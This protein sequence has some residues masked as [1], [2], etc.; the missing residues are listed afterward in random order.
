MLKRIVYHPF[1]IRLFNWEYWSFNTLYLPIYPF[2]FFLAIRAR[3]FFFFNTANPTIKNGG[4]LLESKK[5]IYDLI[6]QQYYPPTLLFTTGTASTAVVEKVLQNGLKFPLIGKPDI[7]MRGLQVKKLHDAGELADYAQQSPV[8]YLVQEFCPY[9]LE[10]GIFY[11][12]LPHETTGHISGIV[13][14]EF[15]TITG[16]GVSTTEQ[17]LKQDKRYILQI[18]SLRK[19]YPHDM[20]QVIPAGET[21]VLVPYGNHA[22]GAKFIDI[23]HLADEAL[24]KMFDSIAKQVD[25]FFYGRFDVRYN[26]WEELKAGKNFAIIELNGAGSEPTHIYDPKHSLFFAWKEIVRHWFILQRI[27]RHNHKN[28]SMP[29]MSYSDGVQM[30]R[31]NSAYVKKIS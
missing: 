25:G 4:F 14:K 16:D 2:W 15:L 22:R 7:G 3:S 17:L 21:I 26:N 28:L 20:Q 8:D 29:Y 9:E 27:S 6:P 5:Q 30:L 13:G 1:F 18:P 23:T 12:R 11:Y 31:E 10:A 19:A 24:L